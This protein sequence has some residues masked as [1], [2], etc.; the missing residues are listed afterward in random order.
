MPYEQV[1]QLRVLETKRLSENP[2]VI[3]ME[4]DLDKETYNV[5]DEL[6]VYPQNPKEKVEELAQLLHVDV[7][8]T[9]KIHFHTHKEKES[10]VRK[11]K[12][13]NYSK[14][15]AQLWDGKTYTVNFILTHFVEIFAPITKSL[16]QSL[17]DFAT[18]E[19]EKVRAG[20]TI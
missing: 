9:L 11:K 19:A 5:G 17:A 3:H 14:T 8:A 12:I 15:S 10:S 2:A 6:L 7:A 1:K 4:L 20:E 16:L 18:S 13:I